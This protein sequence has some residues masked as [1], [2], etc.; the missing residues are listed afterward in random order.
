MQLSLVVLIMCHQKTPGQMSTLSPFLFISAPA[1]A[2]KQQ[3]TEKVREKLIQ[4]AEVFPISLPD[5]K[6]GTLDSLY[7]LSDTLS[8][9]DLNFTQI[10]SKIA[11]SFKSLIQNDQ[12][13]ISALS[14]SDSILN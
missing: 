9:T 14:V 4:T 5:F 8:K 11:D 12:A 3:T 13:F 10:V 1:E 7:I 2:T 6:V